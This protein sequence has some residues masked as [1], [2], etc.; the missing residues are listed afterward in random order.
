[1]SPLNSSSIFRIFKNLELPTSCINADSKHPKTLQNAAYY[2]LAL[3][4]A[5]CSD[6]DAGIHPQ[7]PS[8]VYFRISM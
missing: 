6:I 7:A 2:Q 1:M 5:V 4:P 8:K 3:L